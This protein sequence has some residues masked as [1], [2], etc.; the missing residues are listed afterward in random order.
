MPEY[1][2]GLGQEIQSPDCTPGFDTRI[3]KGPCRKMG[4][5]ES[6]REPC[7]KVELAVKS[8]LANAENLLQTVTM[9]DEGEWGDVPV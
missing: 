4:S 6:F 8:A 2:G 3:P 5:R 7:H 9:K 1:S